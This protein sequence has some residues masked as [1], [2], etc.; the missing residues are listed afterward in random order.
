MVKGKVLGLAVGAVLAGLCAY[1]LAGSGAAP[2]QAA[3]QR[4]CSGRTAPGHLDHVIVI[5]L[6]N[7]S[8]S[9][10]IGSSSAPDL[11][12]LARECGVASNYH[13]TTH[14]SL[15]NYLAI[16]AGSTFGLATDDCQCR[17]DVGGV[18]LQMAETHRTWG[19]YAESM[20]S[21]CDGVSSRGIE[22]TSRHN[23]P[24]YYTR[25]NPGCP[26]HDVRLG[27][28]TSGPLNSALA[29]GHLPTYTM[30]VPNLCD[31]MHSCSI[32]TSD[33]WVGAWVHRI[34]DSYEYQHQATAI[35]ITWDEGTDGHIGAGENC[36]QNLSDQSCHVPL[37]VISRFTR[38]GTVTGAYLT[39]YSLLRGVEAMLHVG[40]LRNAAWAPR[41]L[42]S[43]F[44]L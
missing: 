7:H 22:Y 19:L 2:S 30:I 31:D 18:F 28:T 25:L 3:T 37:I 23:A 43:A 16:T 42:D 21:D 40:A 44:H 9:Q 12:Q 24:I 32:Q 33:A 17:Q 41:G 15:P 27:T 36:A 35:F 20:P 5:M 26:R 4:P 11:N 29:G 8:Y 10:I 38:P 14:P 39:H 13:S 1:A 34:V 6:E